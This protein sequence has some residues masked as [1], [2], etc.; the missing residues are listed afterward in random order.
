[1]D[2]TIGRI[3]HYVAEAADD[4]DHPFRVRP[5][6]VTAANGST[7]SLAILHEH[8]LEFR[9]AVP[10]GAADLDD[11]EDRVGTWNWPPRA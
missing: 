2:P 4:K 3:V 8:A 10:Q 11:I 1:M 6:I 7:P 9:Q 5:A